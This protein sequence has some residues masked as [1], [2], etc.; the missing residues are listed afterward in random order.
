MPLPQALRHLREILQDLYTTEQSSRRVVDDAGIP[1]ALISFSASASDNWHNILDEAHKRGKILD[2]VEIALREY[3]LGKLRDAAQAYR[4]ALSEPK[5]QPA[6]SQGLSSPDASPSPSPSPNDPKPKIVDLAIVTALREEL[7]PVLGLIGGEAQWRR[8]TLDQFIHYEGRF[9]CD[10]QSLNVVA[11]SLWKMGG[12]PT[13]AQ[14]L[15]L[16]QLRPRLIVMTGIC[17]GWQEKGIYLGDV[18]VAD[19]AFYGGEGKLTAA[20]FQPDILTY[21]PP[22]WLLQWLKN[23]AGDEQWANTIKTP[24]PQSLRYQ[25]E[26]LLCHIATRGPTFPANLADW[27][28]IEKNRIDYKRVRELLLKKKLIN[29]AG[30]TT[31]QAGSLLT[32]LRHQHYGKLV[33]TPDRPQPEVHY[34]A[35]SSS[36]AVVAMPDPFTELATHVRGIG[37][38][39]MEVAS[40]LSAAIEIGVPAFAVKGVCDYGAPDKDDVFHT[41]AAEASARWMYAFVCRHA[42]LLDAVLPGRQ[43]LQA[44]PQL[45]AHAEPPLS[46]GGISIAGSVGT[47][48]QATISGGEVHAP[49]IGSQTNYSAQ[50]SATS[51]SQEEIDQQRKLLALHRR[52]L[53]SYLQRLAQLG[54]AH[55]PPEIDH[56]MREARDSIRRCKST[57]RSWGVLVADH[58]DDESEPLTEKY[59]AIDRGATRTPTGRARR[60]ADLAAGIDEALSLIKQYDDERRLTDDPKARLRAERSIADLRVQLDGYQ[61]EQREL[62]CDG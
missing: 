59:E 28:E 36:E 58:P 56:G 29:K 45:P 41:Y 30:G 54:S 49:I 12:N 18:M 6:S 26:W 47:L 52:T 39:E 31:R 61:R 44:E 19:R 5:A 24:R 25:A 17:A 22:A 51:V 2:L 10:E 9:P 14:I 62:G 46:A 1:S 21:Q 37:A 43:A 40:L 3:N 33:P 60:C 34:K 55:A 32:E 23:F 27:E 4:T 8:F 48:Q 50:Q 15:R 42:A 20:G 53:A 57:L 35:F 38:L 16:K 7:D 11:C 13:T